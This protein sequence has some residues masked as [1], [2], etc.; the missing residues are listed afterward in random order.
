[1][2]KKINKKVSSKKKVK[3]HVSVAVAH[4]HS[5]FNNTIITITDIE[6]NTLTWSSGG[7][8]GYKGTKKSTPYVAQMVAKACANKIKTD[9]GVK[10]LHINVRGVGPA[11]DAAVRSLQSSGLTIITIKDTT[12]TPHNGCRL[13]KS[14]M[15]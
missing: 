11:R 14:D 10:E 12:P 7:V 3:K 5:T 6:G 1:M 15:K 9:F 2:S 13:P 8:L 4:I